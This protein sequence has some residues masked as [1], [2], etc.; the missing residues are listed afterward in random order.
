M[1]SIVIDANVFHSFAQ[2]SILGIPNGE[3]TASA[4]PLFQ[5]LGTRCIAF[6]DSGGQI[7]AEWSKLAR[8]A[9]E[10]FE[11]WLAASFADGRI[12]EVEPSPDPQ[13]VKRYRQIGFPGGKDIW[14]IKT[15]HGLVTLC[16]RSK[17][18]LVAEDIDFYDPTKKTAP[19]KI[20][21]FR[22]GRGPVC[23]QLANDGIDIRCIESIRADLEL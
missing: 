11:A 19:N 17:P 5:G 13:L 16:Q 21:V 4:L 10:W 1:R 2:E 20:E 18:C 7:E 14:Y 9:S 12:Y 22:A 3:R 15:A 6:L 8:F 23:R